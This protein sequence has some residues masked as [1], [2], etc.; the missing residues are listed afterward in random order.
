MFFCFLFLNSYGE[1]TKFLKFIYLSLLPHFYI[2]EFVIYLENFPNLI[3]NLCIG[4]FPWTYALW[5]Q[6]VLSYSLNII[7]LCFSVY[8]M[9]YFFISLSIVIMFI[10]NFPLVNAVSISGG[11]LYL[12]IALVIIFHATSFYLTSGSTWLSILTWELVSKYLR[13]NIVYL[14]GTCPPL[15]LTV[16]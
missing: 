5:T 11:F 13:G 7:S 12:F 8:W 15:S 16:A 6:R 2:L 1:N 4:F 3:F 9:Q 10:C 14:D